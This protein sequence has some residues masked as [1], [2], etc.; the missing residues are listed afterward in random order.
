M[1]YPGIKKLQALSKGIRYSLFLLLLIAAYPS[2]SQQPNVN[3]L[4]ASNFTTVGNVIEITTPPDWVSQQVLIGWKRSD[5]VTYA[6]MFY[7]PRGTSAVHLSKYNA[8]SGNIEVV[9]TTDNRLSAQVVPKSWSHNIEFFLSPNQLTPG[10]INFDLGYT[11][12]N[13]PFSHI[14]FGLFALI[15]LVV[16]G[17]RRKEFLLSLLIGFLIVWGMLDARQ[18]KNHMDQISLFQSNNNQLTPFEGFDNFY[19]SCDTMIGDETWRLQPL[20]GVWNSYAKYRLA[21]KTYAPVNKKTGREPSLLVTPKPNKRKP[22]IT[23]QGVSLVR[24]K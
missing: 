20:S 5:Q 23:N 1:T 17:I 24:L 6:Q 18:I 12:G 15:S 2:Y 10:S 16:F 22:L 11:I 7:V 8:W 4:L 9:A 19:D 13:T 14:L 3:H 21:E